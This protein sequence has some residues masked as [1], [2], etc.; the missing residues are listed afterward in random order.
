MSSHI[1]PFSKTSLH[2]IC[3][4]ILT[5][6]WTAASNA[7]SISSLRDS[8]SNELKRR[9]DDDWPIKTGY[10]AFGDSYA[11]GMGT[12]ST[13][14]GGCRVGSN[15]FGKLLNQYTNNPGVDYQELQCSGDTTT[16][17]ARQIDEWSKKDPKKFNLA[18]V[19]IGGNDIN[20]SDFVRNC[21]LAINLGKSEEEDRK[22]CEYIEGHATNILNDDTTTGL[23]FKLANEYKRMIDYAGRD[24]RLI[25][26]HNISTRL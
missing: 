4:C 26:Y 3:F 7:T 22:E 6:T 1:I 14:W 10:V 8:P 23:R 13:S 17:L 11:A 24:V 16:G 25:C 18:T 15:N 2:I 9:A 12:G 5:I 21:V 20:F 19:S